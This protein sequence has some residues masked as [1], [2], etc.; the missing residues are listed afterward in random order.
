VVYSKTLK[1]EPM[2]SSETSVYINHATRR[3]IQT[4]RI[5]R[6]Y[7]SENLKFY[8]NIENWILFT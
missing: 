2:F 7:R 1:M 8:K 5:V 4:G 6:S 3:Y